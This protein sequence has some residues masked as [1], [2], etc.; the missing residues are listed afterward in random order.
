MEDNMVGGEIPVMGE[1][2]GEIPSVPTLDIN[3]L[4][5]RPIIIT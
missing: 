3:Y 4:K 1:A 5:D 2:A